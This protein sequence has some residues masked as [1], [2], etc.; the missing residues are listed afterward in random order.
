M[1]LYLLLFF[2]V[3][4]SLCNAGLLP[5]AQ[6]EKLSSVILQNFW[7]RAKLSNGE[8][9]QPSSV[10]E[11][12]SIPISKS[13]TNRALDAGEIS[14]LGEWCKL[15]WKSNYFSLTKAARSKGLND[16]QIAFISFLH[17]AAQENIF[18]MMST[19]TPCSEKE[20]INVEKML[21]Q[22]KALGI[23]EI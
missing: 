4:S 17:G 2:S 19:S 14:G 12:N 21:N 23:G 18:S 5:D 10:K 16:K 15:D 20:R 13:L 1:R 6:R 3:L 9:A 7:G 8:F 22:S 11:R